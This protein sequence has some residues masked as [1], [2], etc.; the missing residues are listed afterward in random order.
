MDELA[1]INKP[2]EPIKRR[3][4]TTK[5]IVIRTNLLQQKREYNHSNDDKL[6]EEWLKTN[7]IKI[8]ESNFYEDGMKMSSIEMDEWIETEKTKIKK[9]KTKI[10]K[11]E[12]K[13]D[14]QFIGIS[15]DETRIS[16]GD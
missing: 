1:R 15:L 10:K 6:R 16:Y 14:K 8:K 9:K 4:V 3:D 12:P 7:A 13:R 2:N 11:E 5:D